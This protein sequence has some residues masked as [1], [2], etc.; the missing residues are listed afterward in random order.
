LRTLG[1]LNKTAVEMAKAFDPKKY[2]EAAN[3]YE[4]LTVRN[5]KAT[6]E[7]ARREFERERQ[8]SAARAAE[9]LTTWV[10]RFEWSLDM[11]YRMMAYVPTARRAQAIDG[12]RNV[13]DEFKA[14]YRKLAA[15]APD[16]SAPME[17]AVF[18]DILA[19]A[20]LG[21]AAKIGERPSE[22]KK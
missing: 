20:E 16:W 5:A 12:V 15:E 19:I 1:E 22:P 11:G 14:P 8:Q 18:G 10:Q 13:P 9:A 7:D 2:V 17:A 3:A 4:E 6:V 21:W